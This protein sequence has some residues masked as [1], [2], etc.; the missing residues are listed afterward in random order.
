MKNEISLPFRIDAQGRIAQTTDPSEVARQHLVTFLLTNEGERVM[1]GLFGSP[2][3]SS[4][5]ETLDTLTATLLLE[6]LKNVVGANVPGIEILS[7][8]APLHSDT[9]TLQV[10][11]EFALAVGAGTGVSSSATITM[12]GVQ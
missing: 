8:S 10:N 3:R 6:R 1:R 9:A 5:F 4:V 12:G 7:I 11:V 2:L